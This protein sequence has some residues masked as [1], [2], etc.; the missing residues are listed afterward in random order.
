MLRSS[1]TSHFNLLKKQ[2][3]SLLIELVVALG[4]L[5]SISMFL[6]IG[7]IDVMAPRNW[8]IMQNITDSYLTYEEAY[9][10]RISF[11]EFT[12]DDSDWPLLDP[13]T[14]PTGETVNIGRV[15]GGRV[16]SANVIRVRF[17]DKRNLISAGGEGTTDTNPAE[18]ETWRLQTHLI[19]KIGNK[20]YVKS[21]TVVRTR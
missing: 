17:P 14:T 8:I 20:D 21:R 7:S 19:Y 11:D 2:S 18:M 4:L 15:P 9:A 10:K 16:I 12:E 5:G 3:G 13:D 1:H 6:L